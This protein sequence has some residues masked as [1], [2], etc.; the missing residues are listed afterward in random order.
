MLRIA[1]IEQ[2]TPDDHVFIMVECAGRPTISIDIRN[3]SGRREASIRVDEM[4]IFNALVDLKELKPK[5]K[6]IERYCGMC[7]EKFVMFSSTPHQCKR[8]E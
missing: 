8:E 6:H 4:G 2:K 7:G 5:S 1:H 3:P